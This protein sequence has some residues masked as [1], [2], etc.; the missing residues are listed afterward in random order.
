MPESL[1]SALHRQAAQSLAEAGA[2]VEQVAQQLLAAPQVDDSWAVGWVVDAVP[3]LTYRAPQIVV[4]LLERVRPGIDREDARRERLDAHLITALGLLG[5][6]EEVEL[7]ARPVLA[8]THDPEVAG[9]LAWTLG[10]T[11][12]RRGWTGNCWNSPNETLSERA[13]PPVWAARMRGLLARALEY[14]GRFEEAATT[15]AQARAEAAR[16]GDP[17]GVAYA[18]LMSGMVEVHH[19]RDLAAALERFNEALVAA[20]EAPDTAEIRLILLGNRA[21][22]STLWAGRPR[23]TGP[24]P[25]GWRPRS[26]SETQFSSP[27]GACRRRRLTSFGAGGTTRWPS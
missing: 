7:L 2:P 5:R 1:R 6:D 17:F 20:G 12:A 4:E 22:G 11:L 24:S 21:G 26:G 27:P 16:A 3:G 14:V 18:L 25:S 8:A 9:R 13:L 19:H 23:S 10:Y 15:A